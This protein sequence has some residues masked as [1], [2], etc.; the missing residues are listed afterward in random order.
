M[1]M[2]PRVFRFFLAI[3]LVALSATLT[4]VR[5]QSMFQNLDFESVVLPSPIPLPFMPT[6]NA[7]PGWAA[8]P[9]GMSGPVVQTGSVL[10]NSQELDASAVGVWG[11]GGAY[12]SLQGSYSVRLAGSTD[13]ANPASASIS[14]LGQIPGDALS[15][16]FYSK[17]VTN[18][19]GAFDGEPVF[20]VM[21][22]GQ[23]IPL[24]QIGSRGDYN[25]MSGDISGFAGQTGEL[26]FTALRNH[27][28]WLDNIQIVPEPTS[29]SLFSAGVLLVGW[30]GFR[31][32]RLNSA[33]GQSA[34][35]QRQLLR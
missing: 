3:L 34:A 22:S 30:R 8:S 1:K 23:T 19:P 26:S 7:L 21:F 6:S 18:I 31:K 29:L 35:E 16:V 33:A 9:Y 20:E 14:Q 11:P 17:P 32:R 5:S 15:L 13:G 25:I 2:D 4:P 28:G 27:V 12:Q 24:I 10:Y